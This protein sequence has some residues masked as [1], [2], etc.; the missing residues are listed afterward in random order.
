LCILFLVRF[1]VALSLEAIGSMYFAQLIVFRRHAATRKLAILG[2][3]LLLLSGAWLPATAQGSGPALKEANLR[4]SPEYDDPGL[5]VILTGTF[6]N[7]DAY[8]QQVSLPVP[9][10]ARGIQATEQDASG[11]LINRPWERKGDQITY[12]LEAQPSFQLEYYLDRPPAGNDREIKYSW[13]APYAVKDLTLTVQQPARAQNF[14]V[15]PKPDSSLVS[16]DGL[17]T[18]VTKRTNVGAGD[19]VDF[20][21]NYTKTDLAPSLPRSQPVANTN[22]GGAAVGNQATNAGA[23]ATAPAPSR[24]SLPIIPLALISVGLAA[25]VGAAVYWLLERQRSAVP[26]VTNRGGRTALRRQP[27][28]E[29]V[30]SGP[31]SVGEARFCRKCGRSFNAGDRFCGQCGTPRA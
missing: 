23:G 10:A 29:R 8:P 5:L 19:P 16:A 26:A 17:T 27:G 7:L 21:I 18:F 25:L 22:A 30:S 12:S 15:S 2:L 6:D 4:L 31:A 20:V 14:T 1:V 3:S 9:A 24:Q 28:S 13:R 11:T